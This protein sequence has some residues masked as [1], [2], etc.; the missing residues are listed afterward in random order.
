MVHL[1]LLNDNPLIRN[2]QFDVRERAVRVIGL[3][4][5]V[6]HLPVQSL[7]THKPPTLNMKI[8]LPLPE[9]TLQM[10]GQ[11]GM[12]Q[13]HRKVQLCRAAMPRGQLA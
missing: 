10:D 11:N 9:K 2:R 12:V 6:D 5:G 4:R 3:R 13:L 8:Y 7:C 1:P